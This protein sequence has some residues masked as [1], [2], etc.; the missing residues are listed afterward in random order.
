MPTAET[1]AD[2][3]TFEAGLA[4]LEGAELEIAHEDIERV[5]TALAALDVR[6]REHGHSLVD[7][8]AVTAKHTYGVD[9][10]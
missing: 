5:V 4:A 7:V 8:L 10:R 2:V 9:V 6:L 3:A 1:T